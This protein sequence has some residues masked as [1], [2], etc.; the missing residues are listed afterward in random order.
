MMEWLKQKQEHHR[1]QA[2]IKA[3]S[4]SDL[5]DIDLSRDE[6]LSVVAAPEAVLQRQTA[7]AARFGLNEGEM[8]KHRH[9]MVVA[10]VACTHCGSTR[11]CGRYLAGQAGSEAAADFCPNAGLYN[12]IAAG[13]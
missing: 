1:Q 13:G 11:E 9:D 5:N 8:N 2:E 7:M 4:E 10:V 3:L 12:V 6:L